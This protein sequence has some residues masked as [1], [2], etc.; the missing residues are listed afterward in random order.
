MKTI[1]ILA[2][3]LAYGGIE[4]AIISMANLFVER[5]PV[6]IYSVYRMPGSPAFPL[7][8]RVTVRYLLDDIPNREEWRAALRARRP[9]AFLRET[10][11]ASRTLLQKKAAVRKLIRSVHDGVLITTRHEDN[12][13]LSRLGDP[14]VLRIAQLHHDHGF[15]KRYVR[16][17]REHY[18]GIDLLLMLT[19]G[20]AEETRAMLPP[21]AKTRVVTVPNFL[22]RYPSLS[23][24]TAREKRIVSAGRLVPVKGFDRLLRCFAAACREEPGWTLH[25]LGEGE[26]RAKLE[27][28]I[29]EYALEDAVVLRGQCSAEEVEQEMLSASLYAMCSHSEAFPFVLVEAQSCALPCLAFDVRVGPGAILTEGEDS[30]LVPDGDEARYTARMLELMRDAALRE[31]FGGNARAH[32]LRYARDEVAKQWFELLET[33]PRG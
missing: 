20:L 9:V 7:D 25:L 22:T 27:A 26:E 12:L 13:V 18:G 33:E 30:F 24:L 19:P 5:Y 11:R 23:G 31:R 32:S 16:G 6:E 17:F 21:G 2:L 15:Q 4:K 1:R 8:Q 28:L 14:R 10:L 29:R 3:H